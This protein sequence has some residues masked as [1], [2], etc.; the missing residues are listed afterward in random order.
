MWRRLMLD[1]HMYYMEDDV[2]EIMR[3]L[4]PDGIEM[5]KAHRLCRRVYF[6]KGPVFMTYGRLRQT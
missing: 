4:D 1:Y 2:M 5:R 6:A 3:A